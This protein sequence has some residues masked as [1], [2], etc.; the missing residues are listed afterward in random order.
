MIFGQL[1]PRRP[2]RAKARR[3]LKHTI[4]EPLPTG[5]TLWSGPIALLGAT[6]IFRFLQSS[7]PS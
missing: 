4:H 6:L 5:C 2:V 3:C 7:A 1:C